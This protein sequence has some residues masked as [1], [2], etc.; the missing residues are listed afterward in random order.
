MTSCMIQGFIKSYMQNI[1]LT[2]LAKDQCKNTPQFCNCQLKK[3]C[4]SGWK[5][6]HCV[7][8]SELG[9]TEQR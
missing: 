3:V 6:Q 9:C 4:S 7:L 5:A 1:L 8:A 2:A